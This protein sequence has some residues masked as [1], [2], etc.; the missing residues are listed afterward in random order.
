MRN[1]IGKYYHAAQIAVPEGTEGTVCDWDDGPVVRLNGSII[2]PDYDQGT[3]VNGERVAPFS[4]TFHAPGEAI[5]DGWIIHHQDPLV[6]DPC[7]ARE[8]RLRRTLP[9]TKPASPAGPE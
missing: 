8:T 7:H 4:S 6:H 2:V 5:P 9:P 1:N 3:T